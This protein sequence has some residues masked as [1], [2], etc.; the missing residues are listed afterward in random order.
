[1]KKFATLLVALAAAA[2]A[3]SAF[4]QAKPEKVI[5]YRKAAFTVMAKHFTSLGDMANGKAPYDAKTAAFDGDVLAVVAGLPF[6]AFGPGTDK[7]ANTKAK[8]GIWTDQAKFK[9]ADDDMQ[10]QMVK[11]VA[12]AKSGSLD[13]LKAAW[14]PTGKACK[15]C[16]DSFK[17]K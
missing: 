11:L 16:H 3:H 1:M 9:Q 15:S 14:G 8:P 17:E 10:T 13:Q 6:T 2:A 12:A 4:A 7:G 5:E